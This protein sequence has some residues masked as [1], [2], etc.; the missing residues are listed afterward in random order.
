MPGLWSTADGPRPRTALV[1]DRCRAGMHAGFVRG[2]PEI[3][4]PFIDMN[5][6]VYQAGADDFARRVV[7]VLCL[8]R[9]Q[10]RRDGGNTAV[11]HGDLRG[12]VQFAGGVD[13]AAAGNHEIV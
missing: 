12:T 4:D 8:V 11:G 10:L 9:R 7:C 13:D 1:Y 6:H 3:G 5:V 2:E